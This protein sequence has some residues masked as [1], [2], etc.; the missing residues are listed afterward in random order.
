MSKTLVYL[1]LIFLILLIS[2]YPLQFF[3]VEGK[4]GILQVKSDALLS[5]WVWKTFFYIH[6][7]FGGVALMVGWLQF[8]Q[9]LRNYS[10]RLH[11]T[12]G[13]VYVLC[14]WLS[15]LG[16]GYIG[17][18]AEGGL[19][20]FLGF[21]IGGLVWA[22]TTIQ[23]YL[24][25]CK[26]R[27]IAHQKW[28][29]YSYAM[30]VGAVTLRIWLPLLMVATNDFTFSYQIVSWMAWAPNLAVAYLIVKRKITPVALP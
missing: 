3:L 13:I 21:M 10:M 9:G 11:R 5:D 7:S 12:I 14:V 17:F 30:C 16:V 27:V 6:I 29:I 28:M 23:G 19:I 18:F 4:V 2:I 24:T 26:G 25:I 15:A 8:I 1:P 20:A 22:F